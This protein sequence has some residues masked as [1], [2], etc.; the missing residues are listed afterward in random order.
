LLGQP[1]IGNLTL[2]PSIP[3][4]STPMTNPFKQHG[5]MSWYELMTTDPVAAQTFYSE[6]FGWTMRDQEMPMGT[7]TVFANQ[8]KEV[9]GLMA[10]PPG[11]E[12]VPP[13]WALYITVDDVDA[14]LAKAQSLGAT[15]LMPPMDVADVGRM[16]TISDPQG[17]VINIITYVPMGEDEAAA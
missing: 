5:A 10:H 12:G 11:T 17:A 13:H 15:V 3:F 4:W 14:S 2:S 8:G 16:A 1:G 7:Y 9:G 6:L